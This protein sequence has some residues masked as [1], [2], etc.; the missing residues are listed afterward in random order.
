MEYLPT[1]RFVRR[2]LIVIAL[3]GL[4]VGTGSM[5]ELGLFLADR[6]TLARAGQGLG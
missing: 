1:E 6:P 2:S 5:H 3:A 4:I